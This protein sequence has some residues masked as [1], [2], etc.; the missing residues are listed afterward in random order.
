MP[1]FLYFLC[2]TPAA[3]WLDKRCI[4]PHL[5]SK[6]VNPTA[7]EVERVNLTSMPLGRIFTILLSKLS[8]QVLLRLKIDGR[9]HKEM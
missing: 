7:A 6:Q 1:I 9:Y 4:G 5:G 8:K 3:E 2:G